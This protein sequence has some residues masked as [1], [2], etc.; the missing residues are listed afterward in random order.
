MSELEGQPV[1]GSSGRNPPGTD[2]TRGGT[3]SRPHFAQVYDS[4]DEQFATAAPFIDAGLRA[5]ERCLYA[6]ADNSRPAVVSALDDAGVDVEAALDDDQLRLVEAESLCLDDGELDVD[7]MIDQLEAVIEEAHAARDCSGIRI[8]G[9]LSF[10]ADTDVS[11][12]TFMQY[13]ARITEIGGTEHE[14][15][16][17]CQYAA[18]A[19][20]AEVLEDVLQSH[21]HLASDGIAPGTDYYQPPEE[22]FTEDGPPR[23]AANVKTRGQP[24]ATTHAP[25]LVSAFER[26]TKATEAFEDASHEQ[27]SEL[28]ARLCSEV[29]DATA[30]GTWLFDRETDN[31]KLST[32]RVSDDDAPDGAT[33]VEPFETCAWQAFVENETLLYDDL[34]QRFSAQ[35]P[36]DIERGAFVPLGNSGVVSVV[37]DDLAALDADSLDVLEAVAAQAR[38]S[39]HRADHERALE[40]QQSK[41]E[42]TTERLRRLSRINTISRQ[43]SQ[44]LV[45]ASTDEEI[46]ETVCETLTSMDLFDF[47]WVGTVDEV[48]DEL[49]PKEWAGTDRGYLD[50]VSLT[51]GDD[52]E[53]A[54]ETARLRE[55][56]VVSDTVARLG[57]ESWRADAIARNFHSAISVPLV[58]DDVRYGV[59]AAYSTESS[60][61]DEI[62][63]VLA[64]LGESIAY[65]FNAVERKT[66]LL[67]DEMV[68]LVFQIDDTRSPTLRL[69]RQA[70]CTLELDGLVP[71]GP[72]RTLAF[73]E[74]S[75]APLSVLQSVAESSVAVTGVRRLDEGGSTNTVQME[76][77]EPFIATVLA[78]HGAVL[79]ELVADED[80]AT[81]TVEFPQSVGTRTIVEVF[82]KTVPDSELVAKRTRN[83]P[84]EVTD[85]RDGLE[86]LT[87]R[88]QE[89]LRTA[90]YAGY[91][92]QPRESD[93]TAVAESLDITRSTFHQHRRSSIR[94]LLGTLLDDR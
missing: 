59:L 27:I 42:R 93:G 92:D 84:T 23:A 28:T 64:E 63:S 72:D 65:A 10:L 36:I 29:V 86:A 34:D 54:V 80:S 90:Y 53:P 94:R 24:A 9:E 45:R 77:R 78:E 35:E 52:A 11:L 4:R 21:P 55:P 39:L 66:A 49:V 74:V 25:Q 16:T 44:A 38:L 68:E 30:A 58:Y 60:A 31:L 89:V 32:T 15:P 46:R 50:D 12:E 26:L 81:A 1:E 43:I 88:Q 22:Y 20:P 19:F 37:T 73:F 6:Y 56:V 13:E 91:F 18:T 61:F 8:T 33:L 17:L 71:C 7:A 83:R 69:A 41:L 67:A 51:V 2:L 75:G 48:S 57:R 70:N 40:R 85:G 5:G 47:A 76:L 87:E 82:S 62:R 3:S 79:T 14:T